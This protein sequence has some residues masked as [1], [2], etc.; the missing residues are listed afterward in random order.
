MKKIFLAILVVCCAATAFAAKAN[1]PVD[2]LGIRVNEFAPS[3]KKSVLLT[4][5][6]QTINATDD[7]HYSVYSPT[8]CSFR[9]MSTQ[10]KA[11]IKHTLPANATTTRAV[12]PASPY[13][14][15]SGCTSGELQRQ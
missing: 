2:G 11:G 12:N 10:T 8:A 14:N 13:L 9:L 1:M 7:L 6:S 3:G 4:V 5:N 15:F